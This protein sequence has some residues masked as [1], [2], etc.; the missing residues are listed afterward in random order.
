[1]E[2][3]W[4]VCFDHCGANTESLHS[5]NAS[6]VPRHAGQSHI[7]P[8]ALATVIAALS[9]KSIGRLAARAFLPL[10]GALLLLADCKLA[11]VSQALVGF[12]DVALFSA[13]GDVADVAT[14]RTE[15]RRKAQLPVGKLFAGNPKMFCNASLHC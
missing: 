1:M 13:P 8:G 5:L 2:L 10:T 9:H 7:A 6:P 4:V 3:D 14:L 12:E 11:P 15:L